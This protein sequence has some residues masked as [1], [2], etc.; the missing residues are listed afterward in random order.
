M[1]VASAMLSGRSVHCAI[2]YSTVSASDAS[3]DMLVFHLRKDASRISLSM[4]HSPLLASMS[5]AIG[6]LDI[7][8]A[9]FAM[10]PASSLFRSHTHFVEG[11]PRRHETSASH[12]STT[13]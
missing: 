7:S 2:L 13:G 10:A 11:A 12:S 4:F 9:R 6:V 5:F 8:D 1:R 3:S